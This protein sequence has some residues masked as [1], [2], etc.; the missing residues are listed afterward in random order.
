MQ[1]FATAT[2][3]S[4]NHYIN[5]YI[6]VGE[7]FVP[8][9]PALGQSGRWRQGDQSLKVLGCTRSSRP[10]YAMRPCL[11]KLKQIKPNKD[12]PQSSMPKCFNLSFAD[13]CLPKFCEGSSKFPEND[14]LQ[15]VMVKGSQVLQFCESFRCCRQGVRLGKVERSHGSGAARG[16]VI[17]RGLKLPRQSAFFRSSPGRG[18][19]FELLF[20]ALLKLCDQGNLRERVFW[21]L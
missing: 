10:V 14:E 3:P 15:A 13:Q 5:S 17:Q 21:G 6:D 11:R 9:I 19:P 2:T 20:F 16:P 12:N 1:V 7:A 8:V 18:D 4:S